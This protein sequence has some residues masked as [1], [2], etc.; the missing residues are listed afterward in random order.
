MGQIVNSGAAATTLGAFH[1]SE[2]QSGYHLQKL[3]WLTSNA[4]AVGE[5]ARILICN[6]HFHGVQFGNH[7]ESGKKFA[8]VFYSRAEMLGFFAVSR[9]I[10]QQIIILFH[11]GASASGIDDNRVKV[12]LEKDIDIVPGHL[13]GGDVFTVMNVQGAAAGLIFWQNHIAAVA[14]EH[15]Y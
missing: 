13:L 5:M 15:A 10:A 1:L 3:S 9:I 8:G 6:G 12:R 2:L 4:L 11:C 7:T 14:P